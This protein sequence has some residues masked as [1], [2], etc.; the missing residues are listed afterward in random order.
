MGKPVGKMIPLIFIQV[1]FHF[2]ST[3]ISKALSYLVWP[4]VKFA[5]P[6]NRKLLKL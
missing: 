6:P 1:L 3:I 4:Q 5:L 2:C